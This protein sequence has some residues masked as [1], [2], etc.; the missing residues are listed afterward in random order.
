VRLRADDF[1]GSIEWPCRSGCA[2]APAQPDVPI[3]RFLLCVLLATSALAHAAERPLARIAV[4]QPPSAELSELLD[5]VLQSTAKEGSID[6]EDEERLLRG[7]REDTIEVLATEGYFSPSVTIAVDDTNEA[8]YVMR[9]D[10]GR[11]TQVT[12]VAIVFKGAVA[13]KTERVEALRAG[14]EL[15]KG[16]PF[17]DAEWSSAKS[18]LLIRVRTR[19]YAAARIADSSAEVNADEATAKLHVEIDSGPAYT[20]GELKVDGLVRFDAQLVQRYNPFVVGEPY[21]AD[22]LLDFQQRLQRSPY[23]GTVLVDANPDNAVDGRLP[24][25]VEVKEAKTKRLSF[26]LGYSTDTEIHGEISYQQTLLFG[27]PYTLQSGIGLDKARGVAYADIFLP[28]KPD[29]EQDSL[30]ALHERTDIEGVMTKRWALGVQRTYTRASGP[31]SYDTRLALNFQH[32][33]REV[34]N[35]SQEDTTNNVV[36]ATYSWTRRSVDSITNPT[37]G[38]ILTLAGTV[39]VRQSGLSEL[40]SQTFQRGYGRYVRYVPLSPRDQLILRTELGHV[41]VDDPSIVPNEFLFRTGGVGT[42]RG[43]AFQ[44]LGRKVGTATTGSTS[45]VVGSVE[46]VRWL[47]KDWGAAVFYDIGNANDDIKQVSLAQGYGIGARYRTVAGPIALDLAYGER[48]R[49]LRLHFSIAIAF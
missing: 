4:S 11:L 28:P 18:K 10:P 29:G 47:T 22:K 33:T 5:R 16:R 19:D 13:D 2:P 48:A 8:R 30:G 41:F 14:W 32:E 44:S 36:S 31:V 9:L 15:P 25:L 35:A 24:V 49:K 43:Y 40:L 26:G 34:E 37:R 6:R 12:D 45:L 1:N 17:R 46:Y 3:L 42:V 38:A 20:M 23:F 27:Y 39:G 7:L 21:D